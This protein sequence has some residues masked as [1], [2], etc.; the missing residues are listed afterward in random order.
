MKI[1]GRFWIYSLICLS[2]I[3]CSLMPD[4]LKTAEK[5]IEVAPDSALHILKRL[6]PEKYKSASNQALYGLLMIRTLDKKYLPLKPDSLLDFSITYYVKHPSG[7]RLATCYLYKAR[8]YKYDFKYEKAMNLYL[9]ALDEAQKNKNN[10]LL[11]RIYFDLGDIYIIQ[12]DYTSARQKYKISYTYFKRAKF[13]ELA[14][15]SLLNIGITYYVAKDYRNAELYY[16]NMIPLAKDSLQ[17][18]ALFQEMGLNYYEFKKPDSSLLYFRK[19]THYPYI[20]NNRAIQYYYLSQLFFDLNQNDSALYYAENSFNFN[21]DIRTQRQCYR[22]MTN[23]EFIYKHL[24][25]V[26]LYMNKYV[27]LGDSIRKIDAQTKGSYIETMHF[28]TQEVAKTKNTLLYLFT[29]LLF[30]IVA[31]VFIYSLKQRRNKI[32]KLKNEENHIQQKVSIHKDVLKKLR[33]T[34]LQKIAERKAEQTVERKNA[35][36]HERELLIKNM[37]N[38]LLHLNDLDL[39][40]R[41]MDTVLNNLV[42]KLKTRYKGL[43]SK[44]LIWCCLYM[45]NIPNQDILILLDYK[46]DSLSKMKTRLTRK[47]K[48]QT[49]SEINKLLTNILIED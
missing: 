30:V 21:P 10:I 16:R 2:L 44:E 20:A 19:I 40:Y 17:E 25:K 38:E 43:T 4:E 6:S 49:A 8:A 14:F 35:T 48:L 36:P 39:F 23:C 26:T 9:N 27:V 45:L 34:L 3:G 12:Q 41:E 46:V 32:E 28:T 22:M 18:G 7:D 29:F 11:G 31:S 42:T 37:Y 1:F 13:Q 5:L 33:E 47:T 24:D 15:Y